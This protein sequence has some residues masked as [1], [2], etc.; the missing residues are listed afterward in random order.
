MKISEVHSINSVSY[1][2]VKIEG[3]GFIDRKIFNEAVQNIN[4]HGSKNWINSLQKSIDGDISFI[5]ESA[6]KSFT[7]IQGRNSWTPIF[8]NRE[9][10]QYY[11]NKIPK[12][13]TKNINTSKIVEYLQTGSLYSDQLDKNI[14]ALSLGCA[15][16]YD[17]KTKKIN[18]IEYVVNSQHETNEN[19][20]EIIENLDY[21]IEKNI[22]K[23]TYGK[24]VGVLL[25]GGADSRIIAKYASM[26]AS[27]CK[28]YTYGTL[29]SITSELQITKY[30]A[31]YL[32]IDLKIIERRPTHYEDSFNNLTY[33]GY[34]NIIDF[35]HPENLP[36]IIKEDK[37]EV[38]L[39]GC[40]FDY[41]LKGLIFSRESQK[42]IGRSLP[43]FNLKSGSDFY[44]GT[45]FIEEF[46]NTKTFF[47]NTCAH[48][49]IPHFGLEPDCSGRAYL[50]ERT[51]INWIF[52]YGDLLDYLKTVPTKHLNGLNLIDNLT[53]RIDNKLGKIINNNYGIS[54]S[55]NDILRNVKFMLARPV[56]KMSDFIPSFPIRR[57]SWL[58]WDD[59]VKENFWKNKYY[60]Y[61]NLLYDEFGL[62]LRNY[63]RWNPIEITRMISLGK[64]IWN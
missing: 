23:L 5:F 11:F 37:I 13:D 47:D 58:L 28:G 20:S 45:K 2:S 6:D 36:E 38:L 41:L 49:R 29:K 63:S 32:K 39:T 52:A 4:A 10:G 57:G 51:P 25:S 18:K 54:C 53:L 19:I 17:Y 33:F 24:R 40:Y 31:E 21:L 61:S 46:G 14:E 12:L 8:V 34:G 43:T 7:V 35:H 3:N 56:V 60:M 59:K 42:F 44:H 62:D 48:K 64:F 55:E 30:I 50:R 1:D 9:N 26:F 27:T 16:V 22:K 15:N